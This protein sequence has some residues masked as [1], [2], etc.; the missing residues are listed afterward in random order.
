MA[1]M[2]SV[3]IYEDSMRTLTALK[4]HPDESFED[5]IARIVDMLGEENDDDFELSEE[6]LLDIKQS[7]DD[8]KNGRY[9]TH[10]DLKKKYGL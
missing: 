8:F 10:N 3:Q 7:V 1:S 6:D 2:I 9:I 5:L 4:S